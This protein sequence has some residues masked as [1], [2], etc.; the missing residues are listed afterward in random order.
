MSDHN[1]STAL[2]RADHNPLASVDVFSDPQAFALAEQAATRLADSRLIPEHF[3]GKAADCLLAVAMSRQMGL[4][5]LVVMQG[6]HMVKGKMGWGAPFLIA[7][8]KQ[9]GIHIRWRVEPL[10]PDAIRGIRNLSVTAYSTLPGD[11]TPVEVNITTAQA[12]EAG[13]T[14]NDQY[15]HSCELMLK[16]RSATWL[17]RQYA[18]DILFGLHT[19][20]EIKD[21]E[22]AKR[23]GHALDEDVTYEEPTPARSTQSAPIQRSAPN[24]RAAPT[25]H[26]APEPNATSDGTLPSYGLHPEDGFTEALVNEYLE[27]L[28]KPPFTAVPQDK[29]HAFLQGL[30][31]PASKVR[32]EYLA[33]YQA[34]LREMEAAQQAA[35]ATP[36]ANPADNDPP[37]PT[38]TEEPTL[39]GDALIEA[40]LEAEEGI[41]DATKATIAN[42]LGLPV[43]EYGPNLRDATEDQLRAYLAA[44]RT[45]VAA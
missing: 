25:P 23:A 39:T 2:A 4:S 33:W 19:S 27:T 28:G 44:L 8:A 6:I 31:K 41:P 13:W 32:A 7:L 17:V 16:Y 45:Q 14:G 38:P 24:A 43:T 29:R 15:K 22:S 21:V 34:S 30:A 36:T 3:R 5:P 35:T 18:P 20:D 1:T 42:N 26:R 11:T 40:A 10:T 37:T 9:H 12:V